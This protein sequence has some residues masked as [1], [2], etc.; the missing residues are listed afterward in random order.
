MQKCLKAGTSNLGQQAFKVIKP[1]NL[2]RL[3]LEKSEELTTEQLERLM[4][5]QM[6]HKKNLQKSIEDYKQSVIDAHI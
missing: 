1:S 2:A 4:T 3:N 5:V 6:G